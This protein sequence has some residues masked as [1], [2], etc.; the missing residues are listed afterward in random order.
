MNFKEEQNKLDLRLLR[1]FAN[2]FQAVHNNLEKDVAKHNL[3]PETFRILEF[4]YSKGPLPLQKI[5]EK[6]SIPSGSITF[7]V[8]KLVKQGLVDRQPN[9]QDGRAND[10][11]LTA[12]GVALFDDIFPKHVETISQ[13]FSFLDNEE[14]EQ[15]IALLKKIGFGSQKLQG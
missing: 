5:S 11:V 8:N 12:Q 1:V 15:L 7:V 2:A 4:L 10:A 14:K 3:S 13:H 6:F 9:P